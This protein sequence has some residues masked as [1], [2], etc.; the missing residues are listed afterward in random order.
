MSMNL[1]SLSTQALIDNHLRPLAD[2][3]ITMG[4]VSTKNPYQVS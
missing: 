1:N 2:T 3:C 4:L